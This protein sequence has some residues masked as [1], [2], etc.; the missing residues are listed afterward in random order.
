MYFRKVDTELLS[1]PEAQLRKVLSFKDRLEKGRVCL[2]K[3][4]EQPSQFEQDF[5]ERLTGLVVELRDGKR[6][7]PSEAI[8]R[9]MPTLPT[10]SIEIANKRQR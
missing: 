5:K 9:G 10:D 8:V 1:N 3:S 4:Y 7:P 2:Y 6:Q